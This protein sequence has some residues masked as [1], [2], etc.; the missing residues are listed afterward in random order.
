MVADFRLVMIV[1]LMIAGLSG[2]V[3]GETNQPESFFRVVQKNGRWWF[4]DPQGQLFLSKGVANVRFNQDYIR[5]TQIS[6]Y[7]QTN[8]AKYGDINTWRKAA[9]QRLVSWGFNSLG[10]WADEELCK[11]DFGGTRLT[12]SPILNI[13]ARFVKEYDNG[14]DAWLA[15]KFPDVFDSRYAAF[16]EQ[17]AQ[18]ECAPRR[19]DTTITGWFTDNELRWGP[20]WRGNEELLTLF[21]AKNPGSAGRNAAIE[22]LK[23]RYGDYA[24]FNA[25][26][27]TPH[28][29]WVSLYA[30][31]A[32]KAPFERKKIY[33]QN[34]EVE[35]EANSKDPRR[36]AFAGDCDAFVGML[37]ERYFSVTCAAIRKA[38]P[39]HMIFGARFAYVPPEPVV[40]ASAQ[41]LDVISFNC[42][43]THPGAVIARYAVFNKP[44]IIGEFSFRAID[45]G[46]PNTKGAGPKVPDQR[47]RADAFAA[48]V[49]EAL[50]NPYLIGY[51]WFEH[52]DE[53]KEGRFDGENSNY[54]V[55]NIHDEPY[56]LLTQ[57]MTQINRDAEKLHQ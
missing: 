51:H 49:T 41:Y 14:A 54:G 56:E 17:Q 57:K 18:R 42:Y 11:I 12:C 3:Q 47:A 35:R 21:L 29:D 6:E 1:C 38:D 27:R 34:A 23:S 40:K 30:G 28:P 8:I 32:I 25:V 9:G 52:C 5:R 43:A 15:G 22:M 33:D 55:V 26:W 20:D 53:P 24:K 2:A 16:A 13:G 50:A 46:L 48:Y 4:V 37:S 10:A 19:N 31:E 45:S 36:A 39:N 44:L 7:E